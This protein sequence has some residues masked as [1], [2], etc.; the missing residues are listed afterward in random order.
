MQPAPRSSETSHRWPPASTARS[1]IPNRWSGWPL[2]HCQPTCR[3]RRSTSQASSTLASTDTPFIEFEQLDRFPDCFTRSC[4]ANAKRVLHNCGRIGKVWGVYRTGCS[5]Q[6][7]RGSA[8]SQAPSQHSA[9]QRLAC[10]PHSALE[11]GSSN[12]GFVLA[13]QLLSHQTAAAR[14]LVCARRLRSHG[15]K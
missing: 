14:C 6:V 2:P 1:H 12:E 7:P 15:E 4:L 11:S 3:L 10:L 8:V 9:R 13:C 5:R